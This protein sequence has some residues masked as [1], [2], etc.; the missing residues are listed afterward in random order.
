MSVAASD[1][2]Y[3]YH[4]RDHLRAAQH[5]APGPRCGDQGHD[6]ENS[7]NECAESVCINRIWPLAHAT[8]CALGSLQLAAP[9]NG[10][11]MAREAPAPGITTSLPS[12]VGGVG[13]GKYHV[14]SDGGTAT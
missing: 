11:T 12:A 2:V 9:Q 6:N 10:H 13:T 14:G 3:H 7:L 1:E 4:F 5:P 8:A